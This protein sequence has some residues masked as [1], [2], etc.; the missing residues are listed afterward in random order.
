ML[1]VGAPAAAVLWSGGKAGQASAAAWAGLALEAEEK[2]AEEK[3][4]VVQGA[5][6]AG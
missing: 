4:A 1:W 5:V 2:G 3:A 6:E